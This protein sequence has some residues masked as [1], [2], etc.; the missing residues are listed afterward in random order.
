MTPK[1]AAAP[2][3]RILIVDDHPEVVASFGLYFSE[4]GF[5]VRGAASAREALA[6]VEKEKFDVIF[7][8]NDM[9]VATGLQSIAGLSRKSGAPIIMI[10][11]HFD[12]EFVKDALLLGALDCLAKPPDFPDLEKRVLKIIGR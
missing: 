6:L 4:K 10:S 8:D 7:L 11:G 5:I 9:P 12:P 2:K 3:A 1:P